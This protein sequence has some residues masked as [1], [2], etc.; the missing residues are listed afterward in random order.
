MS[1]YQMA[2]PGGKQL[3]HCKVGDAPSRLRVKKGHA[4][5]SVA[6]VDPTSRQDLWQWCAIPDS[7]I[8]AKAVLFDHL[9]GTGEQG[10]RNS[11]TE[12]LGR[13]QVDHEL[14]FRR[15]LHR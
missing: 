13:F 9:V 4:I 7:C 3:L 14:E 8:A 12:H 11:E 5:L 10:G 1:D 2:D 15:L 6:G